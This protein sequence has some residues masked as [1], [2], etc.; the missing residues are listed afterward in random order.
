MENRRNRSRASEPRRA[1]PVILIFVLIA[2]FTA[3]ACGPAPEV[4]YPAP[5]ASAG[6]DLSGFP[7]EE[8]EPPPLPAAAWGTVAVPPGSS[9]ILAP[10]GSTVVIYT[11]P[12]DIPHL[13]VA[14]EKT[15]LPLEHTKVRAHLRG[16]VAE[17]EVTQTY[18]NPS[19]KPIEAIYIFPLP[20]NS[21]VHRM[22]M[23]I[24]ERVV[25]AD[26]RKR[27]E[28]KQI[29]EKAKREGRT[30]ALL[31]QERP[32]IFTQSVANIEPGSKIDVVIRYTQDLTYDAGKYEFVFPMV[33][34]PRFIEGEPLGSAQGAG[35]HAD[36]AKVPDASRI[37][38]PMMGKGER[39]GHD[40]AIEVTMEGAGAIGDIEVPTHA[41]TAE[42]T[43]SGGQRIT[44]AEM[45]SIPNRDFVLRYR[46]S[47]EK[48]RARL[49][50]SEAG[51]DGGY[52]SLILHPPRLDV[53]ALVGRREVIFVVDVSGSMAGLPLNLC[54]V[55]MREA[56]ARLRPV[57]TFNIITFSGS[58]GLAFPAPRPANSA[59]VR[60]ALE[61][62]GRMAAGG[63]TYMADAVAAAL[64]P[65]VEP[66]RGRY[67]VFMT[68][69]LIGGEGE[70]LSGAKSLVASLEAKGQR[71]RVFGFGVGSSVNRHFIEG[72]S[73]MGKGVAMYAGT[74]EDPARAVNTV[75][76]YIDRAVLT[77]IKAD[78][79]DAGAWE[80]FPSRIP[81][82]FASHPVI[83]HGRF[84]KVPEGPVVVRAE[85]SGN[86]IEIPVEVQRGSGAGDGA[87]GRLWARAKI[88]SLEE[89]FWSGEAASAL[90]TSEAIT[91]LG[92]RFHLVTAYTSLIAVD[93]SKRTG[94]GRPETIVQPVE[95]PE[96]LDPAMAGAVAYSSNYSGSIALAGRS[97][98]AD[99]IVVVGRAPSID[100]SSSTTGARVT[101]GDGMVHRYESHGCVC[102][103]GAAGEGA[104]GGEAAFLLAMAVIIGR[105]LSRPLMKIWCG[106]RLRGGDLGAILPGPERAGGALCNDQLNRALERPLE[107]AP[108]A[109]G[110]GPHG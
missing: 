22:R 54:K 51:A 103:A 39:T 90:R 3:L 81:D 26:I 65:D 104:R 11:D 7:A 91:D 72:L 18:Q 5:E 82:L 108:R 64:R 105:R 6:M 87:L 100:T 80:V 55:A 35:T 107:A 71:A 16:F 109:P 97:S 99:E 49:L 75:Y 45:K 68:D 106:A 15:R 1:A 19:E 33:V 24:G 48:P 98:S 73:R 61:Y 8:R 44:L 85:V 41:V 88:A 34:G 20:E 17:V 13:E 23:V 110:T 89:D 31:E 86:P 10:P 12:G 46:V 47:G 78:F 2:L 42:P 57:D 25:E 84:K 53:D 27:Q 92:L 43:A 94:D 62:V 79:A 36:T 77:S 14:G 63:G 58:T 66:G 102:R 60:E 38:P 32:N 50:L 9:V 52:F 67:V 40:I 59:S 95:A 74:R 4:S 101:F 21:A 83:V 76:R 28:A 93:W 37:T 69:G 30:A 56:L 96:G 70:I 29:Y